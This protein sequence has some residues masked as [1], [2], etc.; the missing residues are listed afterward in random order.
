MMYH[1]MFGL[2]GASALVAAASALGGCSTLGAA[3]FFSSSCMI[4]LSSGLR[5]PDLVGPEIA[6]QECDAS[7]D[8]VINDEKIHSKNK[9]RNHHNRGGGAHFFPRR[10]RD[11][12]HLRAHV[13][14]KRLG[15]L[16]PRFEPVSE[17]LTGG[18]D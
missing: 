8:H 6:I 15:P 11:L 13:V 14:V 1:F 17:I 4:K 3:S 9:Y 5:V 10:S 18:Y 2:R 12:A 7:L 16:G